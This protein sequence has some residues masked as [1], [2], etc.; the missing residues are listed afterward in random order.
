MLYCFRYCGLFLVLLFLLPCLNNSSYYK[1]V[2]FIDPLQGH[3]AI[4]F[5]ILW[6]VSQ[7]LPPDGFRKAT[8]T[9]SL[10]IC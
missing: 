5:Q 8:T 2:V 1:V 6:I 7:L 10:F 4:L 9:V 3:Y